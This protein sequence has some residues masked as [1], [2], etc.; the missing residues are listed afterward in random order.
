MIWREISKDFDR[1]NFWCSQP[2]W[3][4]NLS[5]AQ[6]W[7]PEGEIAKLKGEFFSDKGNQWPIVANC[8]YSK[9]LSDAIENKSATKNVPLCYLPIQEKRPP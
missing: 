1:F 8:L 2:H 6:F 3:W 7:P 9:Q 5:D 4:N